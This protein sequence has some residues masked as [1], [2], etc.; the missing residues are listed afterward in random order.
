[1]RSFVKTVIIWIVRYLI[2]YSCTSVSEEYIYSFLR[3]EGYAKEELSNQKGLKSDSSFI[4][5]VR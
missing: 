3:L 4:T 1:M 2:R 5:L